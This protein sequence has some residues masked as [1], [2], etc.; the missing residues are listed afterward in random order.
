MPPWAARLTP[1]PLCGCCQTGAGLLFVAME[2][3]TGGDLRSLVLDAMMTPNLYNNADVVRWTHDVARGLH[4]L[5]TRQPMVVHRDLKLE[6]IL[7]DAAWNARITDFGLVKTI[8]KPKARRTPAHRRANLW[9][10]C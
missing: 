5:H 10:C 8:L 3:V 1:P 9:L 2:A 4:Y 6:N 7:L